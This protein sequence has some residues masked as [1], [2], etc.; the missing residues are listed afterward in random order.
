MTSSTQQSNPGQNFL[1]KIIDSL[2]SFG[3]GN[4]GS[5]QRQAYDEV[6]KAQR[7]GQIPPGT[8]LQL[9]FFIISMKWICTNLPDKPFVLSFRN[10]LEVFTFFWFFFTTD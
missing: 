5:I 4:Q 7:A 9:Q 2:L 1:D 8:S 6:V 10:K 3:S